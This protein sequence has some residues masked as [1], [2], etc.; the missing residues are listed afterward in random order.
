MPLIDYRGRKA[1][2]ITTDELIKMD[3]NPVYRDAVQLM[4]ESRSFGGQDIMA[5]LV[6]TSM[7]KSGIPKWLRDYLDHEIHCYRGFLSISG[8][9]KT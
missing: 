2:L 9:N 6:V 7:I 8:D 4:V 5:I 1:L 3:E